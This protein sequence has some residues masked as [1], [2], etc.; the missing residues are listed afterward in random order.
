MHGLTKIPIRNW[1]YAGCLQAIVYQEDLHTVVATFELVL[2]PIINSSL[3]CKII[4][5][6][7]F[8]LVMVGAI[9]KVE[10][11]QWFIGRCEKSWCSIRIALLAMV[12]YYLLQKLDGFVDNFLKE[13]CQRRN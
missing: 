2:R 12:P 9:V 1:Q 13:K 6:L 8:A 5:D 11:G 4:L 3:G 7:L 10:I